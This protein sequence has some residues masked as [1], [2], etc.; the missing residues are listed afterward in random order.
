MDGVIGGVLGAFLSTKEQKLHDQ[1]ILLIDSHNA[2][3]A[4]N[5]ISFEHT[6]AR[7]LKKSPDLH[8]N[9]VR[10]LVSSD[11]YESDPIFASKKLYLKTISA[12]GRGIPCNSPLLRAAFMGCIRSHSESIRYAETICKVT[13]PDSRCVACCVA[14]AM[15]VYQFINV[16]QPMGILQIIESSIASAKPLLEKKYYPEFL[17]C[18]GSS[19][20]G[21]RSYDNNHAFKTAGAVVWSLRELWRAAK[22][23][24][25]A[26]IAGSTTGSITMRNKKLFEKTIAAVHEEAGPVAACLAGACLGSALGRI[27]LPIDGLSAQKIEDIDKCLGEWLKRNFEAN[28]K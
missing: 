27:N 13:H 19:L 1:I 2:S 6:F 12:L 25:I 7:A 21:L 26:N 23:A 3:V 28:S 8:D 4:T 9:Y 18:L 20:S 5:E 14:I 17:R 15:M 22:A 10:T 16:G 24:D 11:L